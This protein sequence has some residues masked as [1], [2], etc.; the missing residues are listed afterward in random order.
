M[1][2][3]VPYGGLSKLGTMYGTAGGKVPRRVFSHMLLLMEIWGNGELKYM[4]YTIPT[5]RVP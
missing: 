2:Q 5:T 3:G 1:V 4:I